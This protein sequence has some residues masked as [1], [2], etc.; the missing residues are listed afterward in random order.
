M[1]DVPFGSFRRMVS[2]NLSGPLCLFISFI[3]FRQRNFN[4]QNLL[5]VFKCLSITIF[6]L[7]GLIFV[8]APS[9]ENISFSSEANFQ[10]SAGFGPNQVSTILGLPLIIVSLSK[11]FNL[12]LYSKS[13]FDYLFVA[14][15]TGLALLTFARGGVMA[16][17]ITFIFLHY[18]RTYEKI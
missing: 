14:I 13:I 6:T 1:P 15:S 17:I 12:K 11:M 9:I 10:L 16:P 7:I 3:Y 8:R 5:N 18:F 2:G 4:E